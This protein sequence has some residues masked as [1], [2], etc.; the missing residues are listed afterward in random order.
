MCQT[1]ADDILKKETTP[2]CP[3]CGENFDDDDG[4]YVSKYPCND[5]KAGNIIYLILYM[6]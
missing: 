1:C 2:C 3:E 4:A 5:L 6:K